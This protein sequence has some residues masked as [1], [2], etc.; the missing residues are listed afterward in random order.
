[1]SPTTDRRPRTWLRLV[2]GRSVER[3]QALV[4]F[5]MTVVLFV[6]LLMGV[7][8]FGRAIFMYNGVSQ[9]ARDLARVTSVHP[10]NPLGSSPETAEVLAGAQDT[11]LGLEEPTY[12]CVSIRGAPV[13]GTCI[14]GNWVKVEVSA[15]YE[16]TTPI[17]ALWDITLTSSSSVQ[18]P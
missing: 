5:A 14:P 13:S 15:T 3:G 10:G 8:D 1:M 4:E 7:L 11:I 17:L 16:P 6:A 2:R 18:I 9:A 12:S